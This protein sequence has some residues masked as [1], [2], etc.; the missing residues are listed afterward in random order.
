[1]ANGNLP[2]Y[3]IRRQIASAVHM[4]VQ[5][6]RLRD[7]SRRVTSIVEIMGMEGDVII[8][9]DLFRFNYESTS[10]GAG[11]QGTYDSTGLRPVFSERARYYGLDGQL[12]EAMRG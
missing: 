12:Q 3:S 7:G 6:E 2:L 4:I 11:I 5:V 1:M 10:Y 9:Q 8:T